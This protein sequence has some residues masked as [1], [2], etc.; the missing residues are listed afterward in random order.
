MSKSSTPLHSLH[1]IDIAWT[2]PLGSF[3]GPAYARNGHIST[4]M[5]QL[6][7][8][9]QYKS[10][11]CAYSIDNI[12]VKH[13]K[14]I[15]SVMAQS[16]YK[17]LILYIPETSGVGQNKYTKR[18]YIS[19]SEYVKWQELVMSQA[20]YKRK[21]MYFWIGIGI[22][23]RR[24]LYEDTYRKNRHVHRFAILRIVKSKFQLNINLN[25]V[26]SLQYIKNTIL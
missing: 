1:S 24:D 17:C 15:V 18:S 22:S 23:I 19:R 4:Q 12:L 25:L 6:S 9:L 13:S 8:L 21:I 20:F 3:R 7:T 2:R 10:L 16:W 14:Q 26:Q 5:R 11:Y